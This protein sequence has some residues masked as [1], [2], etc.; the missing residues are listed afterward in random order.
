MDDESVQFTHM[1][2][3]TVAAVSESREILYVIWEDS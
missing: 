3:A 1:L 2:A